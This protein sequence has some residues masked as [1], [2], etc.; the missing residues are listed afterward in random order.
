[1]GD[2]H[3]DHLLYYEDSKPIE[4]P[5]TSEKRKRASK[6]LAQARAMQVDIWVRSQ[7]LG[8]WKHIAIQ[9]SSKGKIL[10]R[11]FA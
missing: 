10:C 7:A 3:K 11:Y 6:L 2:I 5:P 4:P 8:A 9:D 1:M